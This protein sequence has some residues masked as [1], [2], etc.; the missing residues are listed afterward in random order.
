MGLEMSST[1]ASK[2]ENQSK[3]FLIDITEENLSDPEVALECYICRVPK[4]VRRIN[5]EV[6]TPQLV[7]IGPLHHGK[8]ELAF[9]E[10]QKIRYM[11]SFLKRITFEKCDEILSFIKKKGTMNSYLLCRDH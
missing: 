3:D 9:M 1:A 4:S 10:R 7:S 6:Y 2:D 11:E 8:E 5:E